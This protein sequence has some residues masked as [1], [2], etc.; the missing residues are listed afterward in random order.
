MQPMQET[1]LVE[2]PEQ[3]S[4][5]IH[6][7]RAEILAHLKQPGSATEVAKKLKETPQRINYH[8]KTLQKVGLV[9]KVGTRQVRNL[10]EVLYQSVAKTFIL[11]ETLSI[12][13]ETIKKMKDQGSL[14]HLIHTAERMKQDA[15]SLMEQSDNNEEIPSAS[16]QMQVTLADEAMREQ[17]IADYVSLVKQLV[18]KYQ[19]ESPTARYQVLLSVYPDQGSDFPDE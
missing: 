10:V 1:Y 12:S 11:A 9:T 3:A 14:L 16:L 18:R 7:L 17:F 2:L 15:I 5:L 4:A 8:L 6:P 19:S 13:K